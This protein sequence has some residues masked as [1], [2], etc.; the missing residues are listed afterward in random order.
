MTQAKTNRLQSWCD[1]LRLMSQPSWESQVET[2]NERYRKLKGESFDLPILSGTSFDPNKFNPLSKTSSDNPW[3]IQYENQNRLNEIKLDVDRTFQEIEEF[4]SEE[5][6]KAL[7]HVLF[8]F[9]KTEKLQYRQGMNEIC[10]ILFHVVEFDLSADAPVDS[11]ESITFFLFRSIM[12]QFGIADFFYNQS[13]LSG[14][15]PN[16]SSPILYRCER[17]FE[18]LSLKDQQLHKHLILNDISPNLFLVRWVRLLFIRELGFEHTLP[19]WDFIFERISDS[20]IN[21]PSVID[22]VAIAMILNIRQTL[23]RSDNSGCFTILLKYPHLNDVGQILKLATELETQQ[24]SPTVQLRTET[25]PIVSRRDKV[26]IDLS[27]VIDDLRKSDVAKVI[28]KE[29]AKLENVV[30]YIRDRKE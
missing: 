27:S 26:L 25:H 16:S 2:W 8:V 9:S 12:M 17:I 20:G 22:Y 29:I 3:T 21:F 4:R 7:L 23:M 19:V 24:T 30:S 28:E 5:R 14:S 18:L 15:N 11:K 6:Q 13:V 1:K 10:A